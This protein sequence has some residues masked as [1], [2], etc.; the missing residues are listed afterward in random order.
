M[1]EPTPSTQPSGITPRAL[2]MAVA[3]L[4]CSGTFIA[5]VLASWAANSVT[6]P[7]GV[8][9]ILLLWLP[10]GS[11]GCAIAALRRYRAGGVENIRV[12]RAAVVTSV[13]LASLYVL[14][15]VGFFVGEF[16]GHD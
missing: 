2:P 5:A 12:D 9:W 7:P 4:V 8:W 14:M 10:F 13:A 6:F 3:S 1:S 15:A 16:V 11:I